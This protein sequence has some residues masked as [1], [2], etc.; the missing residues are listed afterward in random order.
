MKI[1]LLLLSLLWSYSA[2]AQNM[3]SMTSVHPVADTAGA[4]KQELAI[5]YPGLRQF[6][7]VTNSYG[8]GDFD[9]KLHDQ[10]LTSG[11]T[12]TVRTSA[13]FNTPAIQWSRNS[14]SATIFYTYTSI[15]LKDNINYQPVAL[16]PLTSDK[17]TID[18]ALNYSRSD[19]VFHHPII[20]SL[21][22]NVISDNLSSV[23]R[24]NL[25]GSVS[26]PLIRKKNTSLSVGALLIIDPS[27]PVPLEPI[28]NYYHKFAASGIELIVDIPTG[29]NVKK[30]VI[31]NGW[32]LLGSNQNS[33]ATF[34]NSHEGLLNGK[35]SYNTIELKSGLAFE[36]L[37]VKKLVVG[38]GGGIN[39]T[40]S[41]RVFRNGE[42]YGSAAITS[43]NKPA[44]YLNVS[45]ALLPF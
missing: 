37:F 12:R 42:D 24:F 18:L 10:P 44:S 41:S 34:Y 6:N 32:V 9:A 38:L 43:K 3:I 1:K 16:N 28:I 11:K 7:I 13:F 4:S 29:I 25:N 8:Y 17:S 45:L 35:A 31:R 26:L 30:Q 20:Y 15:E 36:Y 27:S 21:I 39:S 23:R 2:M 19:S 5:R 22:V 33:Y 40:V 14:L